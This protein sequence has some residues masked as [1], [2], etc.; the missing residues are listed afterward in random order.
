[1]KDHPCIDGNKRTGFTMAI[2]LPERNGQTFSTSDVDA[3]IQALVL[4]A[5]ELG[6]SGD[7]DWL[8]AKLHARIAAAR[9]HLK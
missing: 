5:S 1:M 3:T 6:E 9:P 4:A 2:R 8:Q 7:A